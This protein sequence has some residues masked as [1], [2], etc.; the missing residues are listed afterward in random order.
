MEDFSNYRHKK[1]NKKSN[2]SKKANCCMQSL[3]DVNC[4]LCNLKKAKI[5]FSLYKWFR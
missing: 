1:N 4:F 3:K 2:F 5:S